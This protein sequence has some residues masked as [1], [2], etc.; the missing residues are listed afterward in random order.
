MVDQVRW[1]DDLGACQANC[2]RPATGPRNESYGRYC[3]RGAE[4]RLA[5]AER[6][7]AAEAR[8]QAPT[9]PTR[10]DAGS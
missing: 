9:R 3:A 4:R 8:G 5:K 6:E 10:N 1:F 2:G 7:R